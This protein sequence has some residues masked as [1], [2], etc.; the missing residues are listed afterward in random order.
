MKY[1][2]INVL[3]FFVIFSAF[4]TH[5]RAGEITYRHVSGRTYEFTITTYTYAPSPADR[6]ALPVDW[7]DGTRDTVRRTNF[8][9]LTS[10]IRHNTYIAQH[11]FPASGTYTVSMEDP[12]RNLG[13]VNIP[14][15]VNVPFYIETTI[16]INPFLTP[17]SSPELTNPPIDVGCVGVPFYHN[18]VAVDPDGDSLAYSLVECRGFNG[19]KI[20]GYTLPFYSNSLSIDAQTGDFYWDSPTMQGEY[21]IAIL[22]QEYRA[23]V[24]ISEMVRDMQ[25]TIVACDNYPP[26]ITIINDTCIEAGN[27][28]NFK[29]IATDASEKSQILILSADGEVFHLSRNPATFN[30]I[31]GMWQ[32]ESVFNWNTHCAHVRKLPYYAVFK[33]QAE[34]SPTI[35]LVN[36]KTLRIT[37]VSPAPQNLQA[38]PIENTVI[39]SWNHTPCNGYASGYKI[40]RRIDSSGYIPDYCETGVPDYTGYTHIGTTNINTTTFVDDNNG[41][42]LLR[43][44]KYCYL[45]IA[46]F[47]DNAESYASNEACVVLKKDVPVI[48]N[49]SIIKTH[50]SDGMVELKWLL[51]TEID[52]SQYPGPYYYTISRS[53][54]SAANFVPI[55]TLNDITEIQFIDSLQNTVANTF[56]YRINLYN[57]TTTPFLMGSSDIA[58]SVFLTIDSTDRMLKLQWTETV[59]WKNTDYVVYRDEGSGFDSIGITSQQYFN[60]AGLSNEQRYCYYIKSIGEYSD[61]TIPA[62]L[63]NFSQQRCAQP[64]DDVPP[65]VPN[66]WGTTDCESIYLYWDFSDTCADYYMD[67]YKLY[68]YYKPDLQS[69]Y[70]RID[71]ILYPS[72]GYEVYNPKSIIGCYVVSTVDSVGNE[73]NMSNSVCIDVDKCGSYRLP[74]VFTPDGDG[75]YLFRPFPYD[76]VESVNMHIYNRWG[77]LVF[78]TTHPDILWDGKNQWTKQEC[79][80]GVYYYT[81]DVQEYTLQGIRTRHLNGS[82]TILRNRSNPHNY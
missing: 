59:P 73:S 64:I 2:L 17:N 29:A 13:I 1:I 60:D 74:N 37:V 40:Y 67:M 5:E 19:E 21:N 18:P 31:M 24:K 34:F 47:P 57:N 63:V 79:P 48:T 58:S 26:E 56:F 12:D 38:Y 51:P 54:N 45:A 71:S 23:G 75:N 33:A 16:I 61:V 53:L 27:V 65:C 44:T 49:V 14:Y 68:I 78:K 69:N 52:S 10:V 7:G 28:L 77:M 36:M 80:D 6:P 81:C 50:D 35:S 72:S 39:L 3:L 62:P 66:V 42:G 46:Y 82:V 25:I 70:A 4:A 32:V 9:D 41:N 11:T 15:S 76:F 43:G 8:N 55:A 22:I 20:S 30:K